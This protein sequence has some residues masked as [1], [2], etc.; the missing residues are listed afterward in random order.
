MNGESSA[1]VRGTIVK[2]PDANPGLLFYNGQQKPFTVEGVWKSPVAPAPN[3]TVDVALDGA[4]AITA[5]TVVD[6]NQ[7]NKERMAQISG[8]AQEKGKEA[9]KLAQQGVGA[10][11]ARMGTVA[12]ASAVVVVIAYFFLPSASIAA[13]MVAGQTYTFST[14]LGTDFSNMAQAMGATGSSLG[15]L[16]ILG[17][18]ALVAPF[19]APFIKTP[20]S[21]YLNAAPL[22]IVIIGWLAIYMNENKAFGDVAKLVGSSPFSFSWGLYV[23]ILAA[24]VLA[25]G[26]LKKP[27]A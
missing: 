25:S 9:A 24:L 5:L 12:L 7:L 18:L 21:H 16:G 6:A 27:A 13:G 3:M 4:G 15:L 11:A 8:V 10:L 2:V 23:L 20:W 19:A 22:G 14:L 26:A 1:T 17:F